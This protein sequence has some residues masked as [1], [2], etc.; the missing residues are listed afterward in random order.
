MKMS[1]YLGDLCRLNDC[2]NQSP[3]FKATLHQKDP[4]SQQP[5][6]F[7]LRVLFE[8]CVRT[9]RIHTY[10]QFQWRYRYCMSA[11]IK[12]AKSGKSKIKGLFTCVQIFQKAIEIH[13]VF[14]CLQSPLLN[15]QGFINMLL[16]EWQW[17]VIHMRLDWTEF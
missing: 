4:F 8:L 9:G 3:R 2:G 6:A 14:G 10:L 16:Q 12:A 17:F 15:A 7:Q 1:V 5:R 11:E 13:S